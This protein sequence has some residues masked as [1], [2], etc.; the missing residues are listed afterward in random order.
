MLMESSCSIQL[1]MILD[2]IEWGFDVGLHNSNNSNILFFKSKTLVHEFLEMDSLLFTNL[3]WV[4]IKCS[5]L[6]SSQ[7]L[8]WCSASWRASWLRKLHHGLQQREYGPQQ[9]GLR[10]ED[11]PHPK[12]M[13][14]DDGRLFVTCH[15]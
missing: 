3:Q 15:G 5:S 9:A 7:S 6:S 1:T 13:V 2:T 10:E 12:N 14:H 8:H 11:G 4:G